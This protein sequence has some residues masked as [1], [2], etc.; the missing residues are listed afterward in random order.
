MIKKILAVLGLLLTVFVIIRALKS[1]D[2]IIQRDIVINAKPEA[3]FLY[4]SNM[5]NADAW[6]PWK[7]IDTEIK[8]S[9]SG[10][11][12]VIRS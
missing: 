7:K 11:Y 1:A 5:K 8:N 9:Y 2:Y 3:I 10:L 12:Q 6:M 4:L